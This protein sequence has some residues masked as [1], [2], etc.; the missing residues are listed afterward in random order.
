MYTLRISSQAA[1]TAAATATGVEPVEVE[2]VRNHLRITSTAE[3][4][5]IGAYI[6]T[7]RRIAEN[8]TNRTL[9]NT[10]YQLTVN[11]FYSSHIALPMGCPLSSSTSD[12]S[13]TYRKTT[14]DS[15]TLASTCYTPERQ[16]EGF[17]FVRL[18]Y[19]SEWPTDVQDSEGAVVITFRAGYATASECPEPIKHWIKMRAGQMYEYR[20]PLL[21]GGVLQT[22]KRDFVDGL[23]DAF[24]VIDI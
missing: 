14:G 19:N 5:L 23:L 4:A 1:A 21:V 11:S 7:A 13:I 16:D 18:N 8:E 15:T 12:M 17:G 3:D 9:V 2:D 22:L 24:R 20:E 10:E 6:K